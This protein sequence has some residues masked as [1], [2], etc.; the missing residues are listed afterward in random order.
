MSSTPRDAESFRNLLATNHPDENS[1]DT[2][3]TRSP[4]RA[5][6]GLVCLALVA[7][8]AAASIAI[9][10]TLT[11]AGTAEATVDWW[12]DLPSSIDEVVLPERTVI[13]D[14]NGK[15]FAQVFTVN[16]VTIPLA[17]MGQPVQDALIATED[18][19]FYQHSGMD[20]KG[21]GRAIVNNVLSDDVQGASTLT[22][23]LVENLRM[24]LA[25]TEEEQSEARA[26]S[27][28]GKLE[29][30]RFAQ[31]L[32]QTHTKKELL[33]T[34]LNIVYFGNQAYGVEAAA[35]RYFDRSAKDLTVPQAATLVAMLKSPTYYDPIA[36][37]KDSRLRRDVVMKRMV[38]EGYLKERQYQKFIKR[39]T[40]VTGTA[41]ANGCDD[42]RYPFYCQLVINKF[43]RSPEVAPTDRARRNIW[44]AG[45]LVIETPMKPQ[46]MDQAQKAVDD[47]L[48][49]TNRVA[50]A[51]ASIVPG[52]G[53]VVAIAQNRSWGTSQP[54]GFGKTQ[55]IYADTPAF[56]VGSTFKPITAA[57]ALEEGYSA[58]ELI[59]SPSP[60]YFDSLDEP[61]GG[62]KNDTRRGYGPIKLSDAFKFS[63]NTY[64]VNLVARTGVIDVAAM[65][66][67]L[68]MASVPENLSGR[69]GSITLGA[70]ES[71]PLELATV[72]AALAGRGVVCKPVVMTS[73]THRLSEKPVTIPDGDCHQEISPAIADTIAYALQA[74]FTTGGTASRLPLSG[75]RRAAGK[76][77]TTDDAA[78]TWF[79]GFTPQL[80]TAVWVGDPRGG[81]SYP[82][83][84]VSAYGTYYA[85]VFGGTIA[86]PIWRS[87]ME[88]YH[89]SRE[90]LWY[91][92]PGGVSASMSSR[93]V[94]NVQGLDLD[95]AVTT[96][97]NSGFL[98]ELTEKTGPKSE[99]Y[100]APGFV[101]KQYPRG[102]RKAA[103]GD[104]VKLVLTA[105]S[106]T[107][108][109]IPQ[110]IEELTSL[111]R[112]REES[113]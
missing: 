63:V 94:P 83:Y 48:G 54:G 106:V 109:K 80:A 21:V 40:P 12:L 98:V 69:E 87:Y 58:S 39:R 60:A 66:R 105:G 19:R 31:G 100:N 103:F 78:A 89:R 99:N 113:R 23:Q 51:I 84:G 110:N 59:N 14:A 50:S 2:F 3:W 22:Q 46:A 1:A 37:P 102:G 28:R 4:L 81:Q 38:S 76:T 56:Q 26:S 75:G 33:E 55:I 107:N 47:A 93:I 71:D 49:R 108:I 29:E 36:N 45:G 44:E 43:L 79:A 86:G 30:V 67:R 82:L 90:K 62:F 35:Q 42:S 25:K 24:Q 32:E 61:V 53:H 68:G 8:L 77:G 11:T 112:Q 101:M 104:T 65:A 5:L 16:R 20:A 97:L 15:T 57:A 85:N 73:V 88:A 9:P 7:G 92:K 95:T 41:P 34:Y 72:Y 111:T 64:F 10:Y 96:L 91:P 17:K 52:K 6:V 74:P 13:K 27:I 18:S 70:Y